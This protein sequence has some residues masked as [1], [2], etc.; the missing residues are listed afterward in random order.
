MPRVLVLAALLVGAG[1]GVPAA[2]ESAEPSALVG[3]TVTGRDPLTVQLSD[4]AA[5]VTVALTD[6]GGAVSEWSFA[7]Q[8][9]PQGVV[10]V[11]LSAPDT[12][13]EPVNGPAAVVVTADGLS[14]STASVMLD[15]DP[16]VPPLTAV[17]TAR[18]VALSWPLVAGPGEVT[19]RLQRTGQAGSWTTLVEAPQT[20]AYTDLRLSPGP[21]QYR[22]TAAVAGGDGG[23][24]RSAASLAQVSVAAAPPPEPDDDEQE[25]PRDT[26]TSRDPGTSGDDGDGGKTSGTTDERDTRRR[27]VA[28]AGGGMRGVAEHERG[29]ISRPRRAA[30]APAFDGLH[31]RTAVLGPMTGPFVAPA[32]PPQT[33]AP[34]PAF[35]WPSIPPP[36]EAHS[37]PLAVSAAGVWSWQSTAPVAAW[38]LLALLVSWHVVLWR[39]S[40]SRVPG[41]RP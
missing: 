7:S 24:N 13:S 9:D 3:D 20:T 25:P 28:I 23:I 4:V 21:Y 37:A 40:V 1:F 26:G 6:A 19:Y 22:L 27:R 17:V 33:L 35:T 32:L 38:A 18:G 29:A 41:D 8:E 10:H 2:A 39:R 12:G 16:P 14:L 15:R 11:D 31:A 5:P 34:A 30:V 36:A